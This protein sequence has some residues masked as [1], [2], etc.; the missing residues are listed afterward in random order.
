MDSGLPVYA[1]SIPSNSIVS[2][3][4]TL[5][6]EIDLLANAASMCAAIYNAIRN[7]SNPLRRLV[8]RRIDGGGHG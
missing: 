5:G 8:D 7:A 3:G 4:I 2:H 6:W 1:M